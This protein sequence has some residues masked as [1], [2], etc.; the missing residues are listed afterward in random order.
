M[1]AFSLVRNTCFVGQISQKAQRIR[2]IFRF[3]HVSVNIALAL[4]SDYQ[5]QPSQ[6]QE[7]SDSGGGVQLEWERLLLESESLAAAWIPAGLNP[8]F[9][10]ALP[11]D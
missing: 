8:S 6:R 2:R 1:A 11:V 10:T 9:L 3:I 4:L 5:S 7:V